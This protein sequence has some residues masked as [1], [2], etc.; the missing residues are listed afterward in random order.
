MQPPKWVVDKVNNLIWPFLW[1]SR[2]E[3]VARR[4][5]LCPPLKVGLGSKDFV[6]QGKAARHVNVSL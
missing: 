6:C 3:T 5:I 4:T 2:V 1:G